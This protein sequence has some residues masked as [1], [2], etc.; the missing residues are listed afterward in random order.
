M[1]GLPN[2]LA[3]YVFVVVVCCR[4]YT[5]LPS[6]AEIFAHACNISLIALSHENIFGV[7]RSP[8]TL[9]NTNTFK[10]TRVY[11]VM[12]VVFVSHHHIISPTCMAFCI[13]SHR[14]QMYALPNL[15][16]P[17]V[18]VVV[19]CC[20]ILET[21]THSHLNALRYHNAFRCVCASFR[22]QIFIMNICRPN[23]MYMYE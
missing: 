20:R 22:L 11:T 8:P 23:M 13:W 10:R 14:Q 17:N 9:V 6:I 5:P 2:L 7:L 21:R 15:L 12:F 1:Y 19:A 16:A 3:P 18:L 4:T